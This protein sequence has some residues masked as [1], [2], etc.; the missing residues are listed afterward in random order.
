MFLNETNLTFNYKFTRLNKQEKTIKILGF[1]LFINLVVFVFKF[2]LDLLSRSGGN[3][4]FTIF[5]WD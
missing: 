4:E 3:F 2:V 1:Y 5:C